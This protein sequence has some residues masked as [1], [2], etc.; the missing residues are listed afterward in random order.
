MKH[1]GLTEYMLRAVVMIRITSVLIPD[2]SPGPR[3]CRRK[4]EAR[5]RLS[6]RS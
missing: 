1:S 5:P 3:L 6:G 2:V 4:K